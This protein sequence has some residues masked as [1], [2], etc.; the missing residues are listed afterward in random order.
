MGLAALYISHDLALVRYVC[1]RTL[2]MYLGVV[3]EDGPTEEVVRRPQPSLHPALVKAVP[4]PRVTS[5]AIPCRSRA[6][7]RMPAR[8]RPAAASATAAPMR[9]PR[10]AEEVPALRAIGARHRA[11]CHLLD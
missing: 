11:A 1:D 6:A 4:V 10:C 3:V 2:A 5:R 7:C 8:R 9:S